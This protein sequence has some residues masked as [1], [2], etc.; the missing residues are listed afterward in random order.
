MRWCSRAGATPHTPSERKTECRHR[1]QQAQVATATS[2][3]VRS[4]RH[5]DLPPPDVGP[6]VG[7]QR[8]LPLQQYRDLAV[9]WGAMGCAVLCGRGG[10]ERQGESS[11]NSSWLADD[12]VD[13][14]MGGQQGLEQHKKS[15]SE[16]S[17]AGRSQPRAGPRTPLHGRHQLP[18]ARLQ[19]PPVLPERLSHRVDVAGGPDGEAELGAERLLEVGGSDAQ[20]PGGLL[21]GVALGE[22]LRV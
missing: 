18:R 7:Q 19:P 12:W 10:F 22:E 6:G 20:G 17:G 16:R 2:A 8:G 3:P 11:T 15:N 9:R 1:P 13:Y 14:W 4:R 21:Q 5:R